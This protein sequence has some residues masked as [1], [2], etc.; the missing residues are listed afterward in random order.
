MAASTRERE[1]ALDELGPFFPEPHACEPLLD[2]AA[3]LIAEAHRLEAASGPLASALRPLLR[4]MNAC[5]ASDLDGR[6]LRP[7]DIE[8]PTLEHSSLDPSRARAHALA[9]AHVA[10]ELALSSALPTKAVGLY[11]PEFVQCIHAELHRTHAALGVWGPAH[12]GRDEALELGSRAL[13]SEAPPAS[14]GSG[15][16]SRDSRESGVREVLH[17]G[18][19]SAYPRER[20][21]PPRGLLAR[22]ELALGTSSD[23]VLAGIASARGRVEGEGRSGDVFDAEDDAIELTLDDTF[24]APADLCP[25]PGAWRLVAV[26]ERR[27][28]RVGTIVDLLELW[29]GVYSK[30]VGVEQAILGAVCAQQRLL[31]ARPFEHGNGRTARLHTQLVFSALGLTQ[32]LWSPFRGIARDHEGYQARLRR[33]WAVRPTAADGD[34]LARHELEGF[35]AW[36]LDVCLQEARATRELLDGDRLKSRLSDLL[37]WLGARPWVMGSEKSVVKPDALEALHYAAL[38]G[39]VERARFIAMLGLPHRTGRRV[40][41]SLLDF[42]VLVSES[43]RAPVRFNLPLASLRFLFPGFWPDA[44]VPDEPMSA[45]AWPRAIEGA[46]TGPGLADAV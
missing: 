16:P 44:G 13:A 4:V 28:A 36:L 11:A 32:G 8:R 35:A 21:A 18:D 24:A 1:R 45:S 31:V 46:L 19:V 12:A 37:A 27:A 34:R 40:L 6:S 33:A 17:G 42:G 41:S 7:A 14:R 22:S 25:A 38:A 26:P 2:C 23:K 9:R 20:G 5:H 29:Q 43:S 30:P 10:A 3:A 15:A 39:P